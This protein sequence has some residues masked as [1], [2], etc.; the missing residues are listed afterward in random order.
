MPFGYN[1]P[2]RV[3]ERAAML[4]IISGGRLNLG[5]ARGGTVQEMSLCGVDP[6]LTQVQVEEAL[7]F[8]G[9]CWREESIQWHSELLTIQHPPERPPH[10]VVPRPVQHPHPPLFLACTNPDTVRA[11]GAVRRR[12]HGARLRRARDDRRRCSADF[13]DER[14]H[15]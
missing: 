12:A 11:R 13:D 6:D 8:I 3:A 9:H 1:H 10:T 2:V 5:A 4:D 15:A 14:E 7:R